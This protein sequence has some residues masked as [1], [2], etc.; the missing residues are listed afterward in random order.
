MTYIVGGKLDITPFLLIDCKQEN[1]EGHLLFSDKVVSFNSYKDEAF[2]CQMGHGIIKHLITMVDYILTFEKRKIDLFDVK[3]IRW[4]FDEI[5]AAIEYSKYDFT[6][7]DNCLFIISTNDIC[8]Y[9]ISFDK[10]KK[11]YHNISQVT[12]A[13]NE[14]LS[15]NSAQCRH[16]NVAASDIE[17]YCKDV[18]EQEKLG[19]V[20]DLKDRYTFIISDGDKLN[21]HFPYKSR[22]DVINMFT[23]MG[24]D[25]LG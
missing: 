10:E 8:K 1:K 23:D 4:L 19:V 16:V 6:T 20:D 2:F 5:N 21:Y 9:N 17:A 13:I 14:C 18:I 7:E 22:N 15:S 11:K 3:D 25:K 24:F 12:I